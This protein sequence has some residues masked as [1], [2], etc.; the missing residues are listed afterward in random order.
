[1]AERLLIDINRVEILDETGAVRRMKFFSTRLDFRS[2]Q[3]KL[4]SR[5]KRPIYRHMRREY[6]LPMFLY[7]V[8][9]LTPLCTG[10]MLVM[11][12]LMFVFFRIWDAFG[13]WSLLVFMGPYFIVSWLAIDMVGMQLIR[14]WYRQAYL[15][16]MLSNSL[17]PWCGYGIAGLPTD[18]AGLVMCPECTGRW[19]G[20]EKFDGCDP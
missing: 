6:C 8:F 11:S 14:R 10:V 1:M 17:C 16:A 2:L 5:A 12:F 20:P 3:N 15:T 13:G 4:P 19:E 18:G 9:V 7:S